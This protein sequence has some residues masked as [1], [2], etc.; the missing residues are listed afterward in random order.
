CVARRTDGSRRRTGGSRIAPRRQQTLRA[1]IDWSHDL[2]SGDERVLF[3][4]L[5]VFAGG[6]TLDAAEDVCGAA[7][8]VLDLL[9]RLVD[10]SLV[11]AEERQER[12][13]YRMLETVLQY[14]GE[15]LRE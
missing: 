15:K 12:V 2:L 3:R 7:E 6:W 11:V 14:A 10:A 4:R 8:D 13:R 5:S 9:T 1:A